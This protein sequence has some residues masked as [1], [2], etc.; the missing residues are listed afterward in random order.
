MRGN[1][2]FLFDFNRYKD[3]G[4]YAYFLTKIYSIELLMLVKHLVILR[5]G[6]CLTS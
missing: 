4:E 6:L 3:L 1:T 5:L 2:N